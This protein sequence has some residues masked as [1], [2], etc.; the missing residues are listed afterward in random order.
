MTR[1]A[2][3]WLGWLVIS[4]VLIAPSPLMF[5]WF[6]LQSDRAAADRKTLCL[7]TQKV[8]DGQ[9]VMVEFL[10]DQFHATP[11]ER[12]TAIREL[13]KRVGKRPSCD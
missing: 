6:H 7:A 1:R 9:F 12:A 3:P 11:A 13:A 4:L 10:A 5:G 8:Y 2:P